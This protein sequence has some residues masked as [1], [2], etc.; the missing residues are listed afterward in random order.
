MVLREALESLGPDKLI[1]LAASPSAVDAAAIRKSGAGSGFMYI[2]PAKEINIDL[3]GN[4]KVHTAYHRTVDYPGIVIIIEGYEHGKYWFWHEFNPDVP[5]K[6]SPYTLHQ[7]PYEDLYFAIYKQVV[8]DY[9][10]VIRDEMKKV[11]PTHI[12]EVNDVI[13]F[14]HRK[15][16]MEGMF[17]F[18][19]GNASGQN[20]IRDVEDEVRIT[21]QH[22]EIQKIKKQQDRIEAFRRERRNILR[23]RAKNDVK[24]KY[25]T[26]K[27]R[28]VNHE[29]DG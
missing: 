18:I 22:P 19:K 13:N 23:E 2:G 14:C 8:S 6:K 4:R 10:N 1:Y 27:G 26:I 12:D 17:G 11:R 5:V 28:S 3:Y 20:V 9:R 15:A 29:L 21:F 25:A 24:A 7:H 16:D